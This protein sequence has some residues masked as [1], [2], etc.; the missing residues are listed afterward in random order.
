MRNWHVKY[1][2]TPTLFEK[3][4][5]IIICHKVLKIVWGKIVAVEFTTYGHTFQQFT[6]CGDEV[7]HL[8]YV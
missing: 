8:Y 7:F 5:K 3:L 4:N 6:D 1:C 2:P